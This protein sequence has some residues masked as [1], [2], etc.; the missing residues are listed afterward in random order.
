[1]ALMM[2]TEQ[3]SPRPRIHAKYHMFVSLES[4]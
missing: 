4:Q 1:M 2:A 3:A